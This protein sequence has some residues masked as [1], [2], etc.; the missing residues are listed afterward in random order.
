MKLPKISVSRCMLNTPGFAK[1]PPEEVDKYVQAVLGYAIGESI[2]ESL[3]YTVTY[4]DELQTNGEPKEFI[5]S[6]NVYVLTEKE[7]EAFTKD[8][9]RKSQVHDR[10]SALMRGDRKIPTC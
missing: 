5:Y 6:T 3:P 9:I 8:V 4:S 2:S 1:V 7:L 10:M